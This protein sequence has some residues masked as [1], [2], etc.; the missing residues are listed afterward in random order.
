MSKDFMSLLLGDY[1]LDILGVL[2]PAEDEKLEG[3]NLS[4]V[5]AL[6]PAG[7]RESIRQAL[8]L[9]DTFAVAV[10]DLWLRNR[11]AAGFSPEVFARELVAEYIR[12]GSRIDVWP[13]GGVEAAR[14]V[15]ASTPEGAALLA[16]A[17]A[18]RA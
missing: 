2:P 18:K 16:R 9:S 15:I 8:R 13:A 7:W 1:V 11:E 14:R 5:F 3:L 12:D 4:K 10:L 6:P 17:D